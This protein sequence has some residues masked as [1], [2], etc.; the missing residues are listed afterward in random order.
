M[1]PQLVVL[2]GLLHRLDGHVVDVQQLLHGSWRGTRAQRLGCGGRAAF[3]TTVLSMSCLTLVIRNKLRRANMMNRLHKAHRIWRGE[4]EEEE[5]AAAASAAAAA[6][7][8]PL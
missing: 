3:R 1:L 7:A 2:E 6:A 8:P 4:E 5:E